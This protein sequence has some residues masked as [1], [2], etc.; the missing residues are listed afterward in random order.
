[1]AIKGAKTWDD[2][3]VWKFTSGAGTAGSYDTSGNWTLPAAA[4]FTLGSDA[5][6][7]LTQMIIN[8]AAGQVRRIRFSAAGTGKMD[9][10]INASNQPILSTTANGFLFQNSTDTTIGAW[11]DSG[12]W[13][14]G[15]VAGL[16]V[17]TYH[18]AYG[19]IRSYAGSSTNGFGNFVGGDRFELGANSYI[20][21]GGNRKAIV[22]GTNN[23]FVSLIS[24]LT[25]PFQIIN[26]T[27]STTADTTVPAS[28]VLIQTDSAGAWTIGP[29]GAIGGGTFPGTL[30]V[31]R[32]DGST[33]A[34]G[35]VGEQKT[36]LG[37]EVTST[38]ATTTTLATLL[39]TTGL[40]RVDF[41]V[42]STNA[43]P[44]NAGTFITSQALLGSSGFTPSVATNAD[45]AGVVTLTPITTNFNGGAASSIPLLV[46]VTTATSDKNVYLRSTLTGI[47]SGNAAWRGKIVATRIQ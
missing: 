4:T 12:V 19:A 41:Y 23:G 36:V 14:L 45:N 30:I 40:W 13:T 3:Q 24:T 21:S 31:G 33:P 25:T 5:G 28:A 43:S 9:L 17:S 34:A 18:K 37:S 38:S 2:V 35:Y 6:A 39:L 46:P 44:V 26:S 11:T 7:A 20:D 8:A 42:W 47:T 29:T 10:Y 27:A 32:T 1:M 22:T 16:P 15:P